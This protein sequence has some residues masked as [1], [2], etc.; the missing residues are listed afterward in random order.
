MIGIISSPA[1]QKFI[2][3]DYISKRNAY[4]EEFF[5]PPKTASE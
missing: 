4:F 5:S 1:E 3:I 2:I